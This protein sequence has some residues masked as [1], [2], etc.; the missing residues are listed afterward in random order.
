MRQ[1]SSVCALILLLVAACSGGGGDSSGN[2]G[3]S[4]NTGGASG[5]TGG[6][7]GTGGVLPEGAFTVTFGDVVASGITCPVTQPSTELK[8]GTVSSYEHTSVVDGEDGAI[9]SCKVAKTDAG[10][11]VSGM[12]TKGTTQFY[13]TPPWRLA[14][15]RTTKGVSPSAALAQAASRTDQKPVLPVRS[16]SLLVRRGASG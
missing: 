13:I 7:S 3:A 6:A 5:N 1:L 15:A 14:M 16:M 4:G 2:G 12:I 10:F 9:V 11:E 8:V